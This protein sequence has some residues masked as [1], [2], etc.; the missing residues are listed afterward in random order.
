MLKPC[1][2]GNDV[3]GWALRALRDC[4]VGGE[5]LENFGVAERRADVADAFPRRS[6]DLDWRR[7]SKFVFRTGCGEPIISLYKSILPPSF[8]PSVYWLCLGLFELLF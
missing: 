5:E 7:L 1:M 4:E 3:D 2:A 8:L 6:T